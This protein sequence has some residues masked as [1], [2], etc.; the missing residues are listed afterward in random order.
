MSIS[1]N[2]IDRNKSNYDPVTVYLNQIG[3]TPLLTYE[4]EVE[5]AKHVKK[6]DKGA[7]ENLIK[8]NLRLVVSTAKKYSSS[9]MDFLDLIQE[10]NVG[11]MRAVKKFDYTKGYRFSTYATWWIRQAITRAIASKSR[12]VRLPQHVIKNLKDIR[13]FEELYV[14]EHGVTPSDEEIANGL[15]LPES[16]IRD[17]KQVFPYSLSFERPIE[18]GDKNEFGN[19]IENKNA[20]CPVDEAI[21][22]MKRDELYQLMDKLTEIERRILELRTG[23][24]IQNGNKDDQKN[25]EPQTL[26][27]IGIAFGISRECVRQI[28]KEALDKLRTQRARQLITKHDKFA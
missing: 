23:L 2:T 20:P 28:E 27:K 3:K 6:G 21:K 1:S 19:Y 24:R 11:L 22:Q 15:D 4:Q 10:G 12:M 13:N 26:E 17:L 7:R 16:M 14:Q 9:N 8:A 18:K 5:L 25:E